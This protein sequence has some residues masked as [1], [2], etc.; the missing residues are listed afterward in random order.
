MPIPDSPSANPSESLPTGGA[1]MSPAMAEMVAYPRYLFSQFEDQLGKR[2][3]EIGV[4]HGLYTSWL[5]QLGKDILA[6]DIDEDCLSQARETFDGDPRVRVARVDLFDEASVHAVADFQADTVIC[7]NVLE[8]IERDVDALSW[9]RQAVSPNCHLCLVVPAHQS[10]YGPMDQQA[11]HFRRYSRQI[12]RDRLL[13]S[14]WQTKRLSYI[15]AVA[16]LGWWYHNRVRSDGG[17]ADQQVNRQMSML[18][19]WFPRFARISDPVL[20]KCF[21]LSVCTLA[22]PAT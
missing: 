4:G 8:H 6:T 18:D 19:R 17:L 3:W 12:L 13:E 16:S 10:L 21:G 20:Q 1:T 2:V 22:T 15:N 11:G 14:G 9:I 7:F 5:Q